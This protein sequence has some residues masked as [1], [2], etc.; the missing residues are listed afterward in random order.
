MGPNDIVKIKFWEDVVL[1]FIWKNSFCKSGT[2]IG[3]WRPIFE[4]D[5][6]QLEQKGLNSL[7]A[8]KKVL[9]QERSNFKQNS[10]ISDC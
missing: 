6:Y 3:N 5:T 2:N 1:F 7:S 8:R 10:T 4:N 9:K